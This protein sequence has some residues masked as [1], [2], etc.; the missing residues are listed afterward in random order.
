MST[1]EVQQLLIPQSLEGEYRNGGYFDPV[2]YR[3]WGYQKFPLNQREACPESAPRMNG[4]MEENEPLLNGDDLEMAELEGHGCQKRAENSGE[5]PA[6]EAEEDHVRGSGPRYLCFLQNAP[7][8]EAAGLETCKVSDW[9]Q[10]HGGQGKVDTDYVFVSYTREQFCVATEAE[11][12]R[13]DIPHDRRRAYAQLSSANRHALVKHATEA[14]RSAGKKAFW[15]DFECIR[16]T[17]EVTGNSSQSCD[18]S[19]IC[20][21]VRAASSMAIVVGP[22]VETQLPGGAPQPYNNGSVTAWLQQWSTRLCF[23]PEILL[24]PSEPQIKVCAVSSDLPAEQITKRHLVMRAALPD[25]SDLRQLIDHYESSAHLSP[26]ELASLALQCLSARQTDQSDQGNIAY[27]LMGL[28]QR[29]PPVNRGDTGFEAFAR[30]SLANNGD[31]LLERLLCVRTERYDAA[32]HDTKDAW[33]M[34]LS[35]IKP[36]CQVAGIVDDQTVTLDG[37]YGAAIQ[38]DSMAQVAFFQ[39]STLA[40]VFAKIALRG[41]PAYFIM[42]SAMTIPAVVN[43]SDSNAFLLILG[44]LFVI[45]SL[46][47]ILLSPVMIL[48]I[49]RGNFWSTQALFIGVEGIPESLGSIER[50]LFGFD[51]G[52]LKWSAAG[53][54]LSRHVLSPHGECVALPPAKDHGTGTV[55]DRRDGTRPFTLIDT[56]TMVATAFRAK[57]PPTAVMVCGQEG[58]MQRA[59]LCSYDW[60]RATFAREE[61][62]RMKTTVLNRMSR[63]DRF[64]F[65]LR[66]RT[67][68]DTGADGLIPAPDERLGVSAQHDPMN[69]AGFE[70]EQK[71]S[72]A[73]WKVD[74]ALI[75]CMWVSC[76]SDGDTPRFRVPGLQ[77]HFT[78]MLIELSQL[79]FGTSFDRFGE[80]RGHTISSGC[81]TSAIFL[82][83]Q[84]VNYK[85]LFSIRIGYYLGAAVL[86]KGKFCITAREL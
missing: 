28:L 14:A 29:R 5:N 26:L 78:K 1:D 68:I 27:A 61:V 25:A 3:D 18:F 59:I 55:H 8:G 2:R 11:I 46:I 77:D 57:R 17:K 48:N 79:I 40:R 69:K 62:I 44:L 45:P 71:R 76:S 49:Y 80:N 23:L 74:L 24:C 30:L 63:V 65:A 38:W 20:D 72:W 39:K 54:S 10:A 52:R 81:V 67:A 34:S 7:D 21:I 60:R 66:R 31:K 4:V 12:A 51:H 41:V 37:A 22:P 15:I 73:N 58:G 85:T 16:D 32:W 35:D 53:S 43:P 13:W 9:V 83:I 42:G 86:I 33:G 70:H 36:H 84:I 56:Y 47:V 50:N 64:R 75:P 82:V 6:G 19:R